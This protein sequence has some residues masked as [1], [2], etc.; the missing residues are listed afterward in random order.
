MASCASF[1]SR[2]AVVSVLKRAIVLA[3]RPPDAVQ[4]ASKRLCRL[5]GDRAAV[6]RVLD[7]RLYRLGGVFEAT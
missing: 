6:V 4:L 2:S 7:H 5:R 1:M 3:E